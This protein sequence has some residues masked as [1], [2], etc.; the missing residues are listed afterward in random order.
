MIEALDGT[1]W[2]LVLATG[3][4]RADELGVA[5]DWVR[6]RE[7]VPQ[8]AVLRLANAFVT[9][10]GMGSCTEGLWY[11]VPM[12]A[13]PQAVDQPANA[14]QLEA[15]GVGRQLRADSPSASEIRE[16]IPG[17][18]ADPQVRLRLNEIRDDL[19][20]IGGPGHAPDA[21]EDVASGRW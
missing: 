5:P 20:R 11:G 18:A 8:P 19:H 15:I 10:A 16:A 12:V 13:L 7:S 21:V 4:A 2:R 17:I 1:G 3:K 14:A 6:L 9:H